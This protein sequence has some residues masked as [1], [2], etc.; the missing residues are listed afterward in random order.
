MAEL[1]SP[2]IGRVLSKVAARTLL[3]AVASPSHSPVTVRGHVIAALKA[4]RVALPSRLASRLT[5]RYR[6]PKPLSA[7][8]LAFRATIASKAVTLLGEDAG[9]L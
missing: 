8:S 3:A 5:P 1:T 4:V 6:G 2:R 9:A 7:I